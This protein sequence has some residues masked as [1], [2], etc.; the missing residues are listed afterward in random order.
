MLT[1]PFA[2]IAERGHG[3]APAALR[4]AAMPTPPARGPDARRRH[5]GPSGQPVAKIGAMQPLR[6]ASRHRLAPGRAAL[7]WHA[8]T[9]RQATRDRISRSLS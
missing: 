6:Q 4:F 8:A 3:G 2:P 7:R 9:R 1:T 5:T